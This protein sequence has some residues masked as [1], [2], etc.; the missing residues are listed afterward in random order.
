MDLDSAFV[1]GIKQ[2]TGLQS[3]VYAGNVLSA[4]TEV[5]ADGKTRP[6]GTKLTNAQVKKA[7]LENGH[8]YSSELTLQHKRTLGAF[9]P[10]KD[11]DNTPVGMI[12]ISEPE[13]AILLVAGHSVELTFLL[14]AALLILSLIPIYFITRSLVKQLD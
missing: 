7:V 10:V 6:V 8:A 11:V 12:L 3:S 5:A 2:A 9:L 1:D 14:T 13:S 4:T